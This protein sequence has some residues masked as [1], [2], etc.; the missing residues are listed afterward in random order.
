MKSQMAQMKPKKAQMA[1]TTD[2]GVDAEATL[3]QAYL[4][5]L[6][7]T[8][9]GQTVGPTTLLRPI[10]EAD[11]LSGRRA[12]LARALGV[13][14]APGVPAESV[15][16][17]LTANDDGRI[18]VFGLPPWAMTMIGDRRMDNIET[19]VRRAL[20]GN[21][22]GDLIETGVW[23]GGATIFMRGLLGAFGVRDRTV[24]VADSF[25]GVPAPDADRYPADE[26]MPLHL[27]SPLAVSAD[28]VRANF[29]RFGLL[30]DQVEFVEGWFRDTLPRLRGHQWAV[31]RLDGDLYE[32]TTNALDNL[33]DGLSP[34][35]WLIVDDYE[36]V[37]CRRA[38]NDFRE[39]NDIRE[40]IIEIDW[41]GICWQKGG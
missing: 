34:G 6:K 18:G 31:V 4:E 33:Y 8:L 22:P 15:E 23:R 25:Q 21:V 5:L 39:R 9:L 17:D 40:P 24:Y 7:R 20:E 32:S 37:A 16:F 27:W 13:P 30:D 28:E 11:E 10:A 38:V 14:P 3:R 2:G 26:G 41:T 19:C 36:I 29:A 12:R 1:P 35:G